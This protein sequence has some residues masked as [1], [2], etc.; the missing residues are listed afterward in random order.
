MSSP[1]FLDPTAIF[2]HFRGA[3]ATELLTVA[4]SHLGVF[5]RIGPEGKLVA[6]LQRELALADR[7]MRV[8]LTAL[9]A[10]ELLEESAGRVVLSPLATQALVR[11]G[12]KF[13]GDYIGLAAES[14]GVLEM[15]RR[16]KSNRPA[17]A[18]APEQGAAFVFREGLESAMEQEAS[19]RRLTLSLAGRANNVAPV[20]A[21]AVDLPPGAR[22]LD[23]A[24]GSGIYS[25]ELLLRN[26]TA[27][28]VLLDRPEVLKVA[29]ELAERHGVADRV[30]WVAGDMFTA[31]LPSD[32]N[33]VLLSNVLHD[34]DVP[35]CQQL[36]KRCAA[37]LPPGGE[38]WIHDVFLSD[39]LGGPLAIA[40]YSAALFTLTEGRAYSAREYR[41]WL[42]GAG[43]LPGDITP[44][45]IHCGV[46][47][48]TKPHLPDRT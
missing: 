3:Y 29:Q 1:P 2:E 27:T 47:P 32:C 19:A 25:F 14:P 37:V 38:L 6:D 46:L 8:L 11:G 42:R 4:V 15:V 35:Q 45:L 30:E 41:T 7:P 28:A 36:L 24:A 21:W 5:E 13:V 43:L 17:G 16:L 23:I 20:L 12:E 40:L 44:T 22:I 26:S 33:L 48:A 31:E 9:R 18:D 39:D 10:M 34:W